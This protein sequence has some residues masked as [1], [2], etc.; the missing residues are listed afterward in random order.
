MSNSLIL[1]DAPWKNRL[2][3]WVVIL[4]LILIF[5]VIFTFRSGLE[6]KNLIAPVTF[7][8]CE[9]IAV[10]VES[11]SDSVPVLE[12]DVS[13]STVARSE[14]APAVPLPPEKPRLN[15]TDIV[16]PVQLAAV[17]S[18][19]A[20][21]ASS[22]SSVKSSSTGDTTRLM[23]FNPYA[24]FLALQ[25]RLKLAKKELDWKHL[26]DKHQRGPFS[27]EGVGE[28]DSVLPMLTGIRIADGFVAIMTKDTGHLQDIAEEVER[29]A[30]AQNIDRKVLKGADGVRKA[31]ARKDWPSIITELGFL[32]AEIMEQYNGGDG[33]PL[34][35]EEPKAIL[36]VMAAFLQ[37]CTY[38]AD[39]VSSNQPDLDLSNHLRI[40]RYLQ[41]LV[42][43]QKR[44]PD[45]MK[46][47]DRV[48]RCLD[49]IERVKTLLDIKIDENISK[50]KV[51]E[52][53]KIANETLTAISAK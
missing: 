2:S 28:P 13:S 27:A 41:Q 3:S 5:V 20:S 4:G 6:S 11:R 21:S 12:S 23:P 33:K 46:N 8:P 7:A 24:Q 10:I 18:P 36:A 49:G 15:G 52:I 40:G 34:G 32:Q 45:S 44:L 31:V 38:A 17:E 25:I 22:S 50:D 35:P 26:L 42:D 19:P 48:K 53:E 51:Q 47:N 1:A 37:A 29:L 9:A 16:A 30:I 43:R 39:I 14:P